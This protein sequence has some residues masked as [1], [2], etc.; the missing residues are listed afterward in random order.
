MFLPPTY[1]P[2]VSYINWRI[3]IYSP[4]TVSSWSEAVPYYQTNLLRLSL[5]P[6]LQGTVQTFTI[7]LYSLDFLF[8][9]PFSLECLNIF[10]CYYDY[11]VL[12]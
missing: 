9:R 11:Y 2:S 8:A 10:A 12:C 1:L 5:N 4:N 3:V 7:E 6:K